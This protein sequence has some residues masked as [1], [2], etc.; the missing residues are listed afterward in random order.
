MQTKQFEHGQRVWC[1]DGRRAKFVCRTDEGIVIKFGFYQ[2]GQGDED[3]YFDGVDIVSEVFDAAPVEAIEAKVVELE[4]KAATLRQEI[5]E[6]QKAIRDGERTVKERLAKLAKFDALVNLEAFIDGKI[7][8]FVEVGPYDSMVKV[9][10]KGQELHRQDDG[11]R[12]DPKEMKLMSLFGRTGG[13]LLWKVNDYYD[14][15]GHWHQVYPCASLEEAN[16]LAAK[17]IA[18]KFE[19]LPIDRP[20]V[21]EPLVKS[22]ELIGAPIPER[23]PA[24]IKNYKRKSAEDK[25]LKLKTEQ[26]ALA[27]QLVA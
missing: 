25:I 9:L 13:A 26:E 6:S 8:H 1:R 11:S 10:T 16:A 24:A 5:L 14:G 21:F 7:T 27:A 3:E 20:W 12:F 15:S 22:A 2:P 19:T 4:A 17:I 18:E 23:I